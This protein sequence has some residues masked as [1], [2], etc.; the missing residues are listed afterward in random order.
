MRNEL[1]KLN[2]T[3]IS[4]LTLKEI[5]TDVSFKKFLK[6][7][8]LITTSIGKNNLKFIIDDLKFIIDQIGEKQKII[9]LCC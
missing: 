6:D 3:N 5:K 1:V 9:I 8:F 2:V 4:A 7:T